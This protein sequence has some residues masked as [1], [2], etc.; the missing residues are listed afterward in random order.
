MAGY[1]HGVLLAS[2]SGAG[3]SLIVA[4]TFCVH[5]GYGNTVEYLCRH[6]FSGL[7]ESQILR[8]SL[9]PSV[10]VGRVDDG[11]LSA[12]GIP[13]HVIHR[14]PKRGDLSERRVPIF[15]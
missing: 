3:R 9:R 7:V 6:Y 13:H 5:A 15:A 11:E 4:G 14:E 8:H 10:G 1:V 12:D 2:I